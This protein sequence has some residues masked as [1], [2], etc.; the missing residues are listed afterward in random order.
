ML[1]RVVLR[2]DEPRFAGPAADGLRSAGYDVVTLDD[3]IAALDVL[4]DAQQIDLLITRVRFGPGKP[5]G[6]SVALMAR[7]YRPGLKVLFVARAEYRREAEELGA[8]LPAP[9]SVPDLVNALGR[10]LEPGDP[11]PR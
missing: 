5:H 2:H 6:I 1:V 9:A 7:T 8:F 10:L 4:Q 3:P 11:T